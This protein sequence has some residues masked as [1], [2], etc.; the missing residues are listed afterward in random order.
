YPA[1]DGSSSRTR[2]GKIVRLI[3]V[4]HAVELI[5]IY[6]TMMDCSVSSTTSLER[7]DN[8]YL[9]AFSDKEWYHTLHADF[10]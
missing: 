8:F 3:D 6:G 10:A 1:S 7:Y 2:I 4:T 9:N 5:P